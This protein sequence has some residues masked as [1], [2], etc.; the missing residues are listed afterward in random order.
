MNASGGQE[1]ELHGS[2]LDKLET[3]R[4]RTCAVV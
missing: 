4:V 1:D 2:F 3:E